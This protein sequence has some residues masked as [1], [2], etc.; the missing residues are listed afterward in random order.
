MDSHNTETKKTQ[1]IYGLSWTKND[2]DEWIQ[3]SWPGGNVNQLNERL[4]AGLTSP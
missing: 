3:V 4:E 1:I 2:A